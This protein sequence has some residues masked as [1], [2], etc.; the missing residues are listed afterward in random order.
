MKEII[1]I[2]LLGLLA[3]FLASII[4]TILA[5]ILLTVVPCSW[6]G[7]SFEGA[8]GYAAIPILIISGGTLLI[9]LTTV[10]SILLINKN[11]KL[12]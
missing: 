10:F 7:S 2:G 9:V 12:K 3:F 11:K 1:D 6:L 8:C 4:V 5:W